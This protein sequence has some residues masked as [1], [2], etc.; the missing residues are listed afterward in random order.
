MSLVGADLGGMWVVT[1]GEEG[2]WVFRIHSHPGIQ[3]LPA[4]LLACHRHRVKRSVFLWAL[5]VRQPHTACPCSNDTQLFFFP[6]A[7]ML[8]QLCQSQTDGTVRAGNH[9]PGDMKGN[10]RWQRPLGFKFSS[11]VPPV[12]NRCYIFL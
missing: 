8:M 9:T 2:A 12:I 11:P 1:P 10:R 6:M 3:K 4:H 7:E 5:P